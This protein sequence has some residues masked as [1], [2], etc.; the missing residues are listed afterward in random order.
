[1]TTTNAT[2]H[3]QPT[4]TTAVDTT[5]MAPLSPM[6]KSFI[7]TGVMFLL[8]LILGCVY[9]CIYYQQM[10]LGARKRLTQLF[11]STNRIGIGGA[12]RRY[13][14]IEVTPKQR[15]HAHISIFGLAIGG[16]QSS[17]GKQSKYSA[18]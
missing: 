1:M 13:R 16:R 15:T 7:A 5:Q 12:A 4:N 17:K 2:L 10:S 8:T 14:D 9:A 6:L 18:Y 3:L 11:G